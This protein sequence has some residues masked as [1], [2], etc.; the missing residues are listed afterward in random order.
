MA[1]DNPGSA[2]KRAAHEQDES[3]R[4]QDAQRSGGK[5]EFKQVKS[6][7]QPPRSTG[8]PKPL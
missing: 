6:D 1:D 3:G 8:N 2:R 5:K 7:G 4:A